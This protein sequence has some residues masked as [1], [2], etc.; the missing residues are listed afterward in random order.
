MRDRQQV[1]GGIAQQE[2]LSSSCSNN[3]AK[4]NNSAETTNMSNENI[5]NKIAKEL[6][7]EY[8]TEPAS[9]STAKSR[10]VDSFNSNFNNVN[11]NHGNFIIC[12]TLKI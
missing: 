6:N 12:K 9:S 10:T 2:V 11:Q 8:K 5:L 3:Q 7:R 1:P 4:S